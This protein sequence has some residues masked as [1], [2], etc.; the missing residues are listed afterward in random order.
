[1]R[2][3]IIGGSKGIGKSISQKLRNS[4]LR[5]FHRLLKN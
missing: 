1:M 2:A 5:L 4:N 3:L